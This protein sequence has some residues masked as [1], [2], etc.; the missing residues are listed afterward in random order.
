MWVDRKL[1][2]RAGE[3]IGATLRRVQAAFVKWATRMA[4]ERRKWGGIGFYSQLRKE[5]QPKRGGTQAP[6][7]YWKRPK[8]FWKLRHRVGNDRDRLGSGRN[9]F[10]NGPHGLG[11]GFLEASGDLF[12][13]HRSLGHKQKVG[14]LGRVREGLLVL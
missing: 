11:N 9:L 14:S 7:S 12:Q 1:F 10:A 6:K 13:N 8:S 4:D 2:Q 3:K 5:E